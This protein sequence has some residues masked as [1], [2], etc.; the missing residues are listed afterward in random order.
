MS[1]PLGTMQEESKEKGATWRAISNQT[2]FSRVNIS[3]W[4]GSEEEPYNVEQW[5][6][7]TSNRNRTYQHLYGNQIDNTIMLA[8]GSYAN[9]G[10]DLLWNQTTGEGVIGADLA[11]TAVSSSGFSGNIATTD[12]QAQKLVPVNSELMWNESYFRSYL[13][14]YLNAKEALAEYY[15]APTVRTRNSYDIPLANFTVKMRANHLEGSIAGGS[16]T[17]GISRARINRARLLMSTV[18]SRSTP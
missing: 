12:V 11:V 9:W 1:P 3:S 8:G 16:V 5:A 17:S 10:L 4:F 18:H 14:L 13:T 7:H 15:G 6:S 2:I